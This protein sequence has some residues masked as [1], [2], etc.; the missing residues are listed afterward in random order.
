MSAPVSTFIGSVSSGNFSTCSFLGLG[1]SGSSPI[2]VAAVHIGILEMP[3][4]SIILQALF[5]GCKPQAATYHLRIQ[6]DI[7]CGNRA[8]QQNGFCHRQVNTFRQDSIA[9]KYFN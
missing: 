6:A 1:A 2:S 4:Q 5:P 9:D 3:T 8:G 7:G